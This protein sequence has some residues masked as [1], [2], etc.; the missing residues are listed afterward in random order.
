MAQDNKSNLPPIEDL[1][2]P[3]FIQDIVS[4]AMDGKPPDPTKV[5]RLGPILQELARQYRETIETE[6][7]GTGVSDQLDCI[8]RI[9][10][11]AATLDAEL[12]EADDDSTE[13]LWRGYNKIKRLREDAQEDARA[14]RSR[15]PRR[16]HDGDRHRRE[17]PQINTHLPPGMFRIQEIH[18]GA[19]ELVKIA[20]VA[21]KMLGATSGAK[22]GPG[23]PKKIADV[24][25]G[26]AAEIGC[27]FLWLTGERPKRTVRIVENENL[28]EGQ[29]SIEVGPWY[30]FL[31][32]IME[33]IF[34]NTN[35]V[36]RCA[37]KVVHG[38][39]ANPTQYQTSLIHF[40]D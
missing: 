20:T 10:N 36:I 24:R 18:N 4:M 8:A 32:A 25:F 17:R 13:Q 33:K 27:I 21:G 40:Q 14:R 6:K 37:R 39:S 28:A 1:A 9:R 7:G 15:R 5:E 23:V 38:M 16:Q 26:A 35:G 12:A 22:G 11:A 34:G 3:E 2:R 30:D 19:T 29:E 31:G